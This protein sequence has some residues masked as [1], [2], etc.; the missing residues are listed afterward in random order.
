MKTN[1][2][3]NLDS[4]LG[5]NRYSTDFEGI[6]GKI[7]IS[8][9]DFKVEELINPTILTNITEKPSAN[10][11][12]P[13]FKLIKEGVDTIHAIQKIQNH[14]GCNVH[15]LGLKDR[16]AQTIQYISP[17]QS[18]NDIP[19]NIHI[20]K[21]ISL[22]FFG[23]YHKLLTRKD[24]VGNRFTIRIRDIQVNSEH[25][26]KAFK[27]LKQN[28]KN[29]SI[30][31]YYG[32][33]RFGSKRP[34]NHLIGKAIVKRKFEK[35]VTLILSQLDEDKKN[36]INEDIKDPSNYHN[37]LKKLSR[38]QDIEKFVLKALIKHPDNWISALR[39]VPLTVRRLYIQAYQAY[40]FNHAMSKAVDNNTNLFKVENGDIFG[41][42]NLEDGTITDIR[43][44]SDKVLIC[45][46]KNIFPL[47]QLVGYTF[48][49]GT[50][51]FD[52]LIQEVLKEEDISPKLFYNK[53]MSELSMMGSF[54][55]PSLLVNDLKININTKDLGS[56]LIH[57]SL[58]KGSYATILLRE[59]IKPA[60]PVRAGF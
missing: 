16:Q 56:T 33:Q 20:T 36:S 27:D 32:Y 2:Q 19:K 41:I 3:K 37:I 14:F 28:I 47:V 59:L 4:K 49:A 35:A 15:Y 43:R 54:R 58:L 40:I 1:I 13:I 24:L 30:P 9:Q 42:L 34:V 21:Q 22:D 52:H 55:I 38:N 39:S 12:Y 45:N 57:F 44:S 11:I 26:K 6:G 60:D 17:K 7:K 10:N 18:R 23:Y 53:D 31:N 48:R 50:G 46:D 8:F 25:Q 51:R 29:M 5:I